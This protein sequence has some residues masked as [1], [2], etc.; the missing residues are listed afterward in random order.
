M[1]RFLYLATL[2]TALFFAGCAQEFDDSKIW[3]EIDSI[4]SRV[5]AL[6][7]VTNAYKNNLFIKSVNQIDNG[8]IITFSDGSQ[9]TVVNTIVNG[10]N[11]DDIT[12]IKEVKIGDDE[13]TFM[14]TNGD[15]FSIPLYS[16]LS[17]TFETADLVAMSPNSSREI[18]YTIK[19]ILQDDIKVE[20]VS[21]ADIKAKAV[22]DDASGLS[23]LI[24]IQTGA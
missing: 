1:K 18:G 6:E 2:V 16:T 4:K 19:S 11:K 8:Y 14:L 21:S 17:I 9:A 23:G 15:T 22:A 5:S 3:E 20:V 12:Y 10:D 13:V 24:E 7:T